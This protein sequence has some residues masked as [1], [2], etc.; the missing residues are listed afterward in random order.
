MKIIPYGRQSISEAD[1]KAV[2]NVLRGDWLTCGSHVTAFERAVAEYCGVKHAVAVCNGTAAL[3]VA[4]MALDVGVGDIGVTSPLTFLASANCIAY[5][6]G[7]PDF[8][9][10]DMDTLCMSPELLEEWI[11]NNG[12]P[13][14]IVP[15]DFAGVPA[16]LPRIWQ[17]AQKHGFKVIE[18]AAHSLGSVYTY[19]GK[20]YKCGCCEQS[21][22]AILS[23]HPVKT[24]TSGEGGMVLTN[25]DILAKRARMFTSHGT[26][27]DPTLF[28][29]WAIESDGQISVGA[30]VQETEGIAPWLYQQ[31]LLGYN[32]RLT[33]IHSALGISQMKR[34]DEFALRRKEIVK[35]YNKAFGTIDGLI[36][37]P[38]P[39]NMDPVN[40]LYVLRLASDLKSLR[41][42]I[43]QKLK[44]E[45]ILTQ[46]HYIPVHLQPWYASSFGYGVAKC[47][48]AEGVYESCISLPLFPAMT[49]KDIT[50]VINAMIKVLAS[51]QH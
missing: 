22:M 26:Q 19:E 25:D 4:C 18:D 44:D 7:C 24:I 50:S 14:V 29:A 46:V 51:T 2:V 12:T 3:H 16:D 10:I 6:G 28:Q 41:H 21:D 8:V 20:D 1:I 42:P 45:G 13:K 35:M 43:V 34:L 40:H 47:P 17:L 36:I 30:S 39:E 49:N 33:D 5:C 9:D 31:Q 15:V 37:P 11:S 27:M 23:F 38:R 48:V 32:Y